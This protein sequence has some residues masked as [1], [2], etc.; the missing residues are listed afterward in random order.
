[1]IDN[2]VEIQSDLNESLTFSTNQLELRR[3]QST[4]T[5]SEIEGYIY[6]YR[7]QDYMTSNNTNFKTYYFDLMATLQF[8]YVFP[9]F[10]LTFL[11][12][13]FLYCFSN[14][15]ARLWNSGLPCDLNFVRWFVSFVICC[16]MVALISTSM[17]RRI[18]ETIRVKNYIFYSRRYQIKHITTSKY[19][20]FIPYL[21]IDLFHIAWSIAGIVIDK[22]YLQE[23]CSSDL[24]Y[25]TYTGNFL[26]G[27][28]FAFILR[29]IYL[30]I[31]FIFGKQLFQ[32]WSQ[33]EYRNNKFVVKLKSELYIPDIQ[34]PMGG[35]LSNDS[36]QDDN[37]DQKDKNEEVC[38]SICFCEYESG[39]RIVRLPCD[40][41]RHVF[42][43]SC[44]KQWLDRNDLCPLCKQ[45]IILM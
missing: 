15:L 7:D 35:L 24:S 37:Y 10:L 19:R 43:D 33:R 44:I 25:V 2:N 31:F 5:T 18:Y 21:I 9:Y 12:F 8:T 17:V 28:G 3:A 1:M 6:L 40:S 30:L 27:M 11:S 32:K 39:E 41:Q 45:N 38:C 29:L 23:T 13:A 34:T 16:P 42:H 36:I 14:E 20:F 26:V 22:I 4:G